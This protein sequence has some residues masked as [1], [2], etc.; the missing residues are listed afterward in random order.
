[1]GN[2]FK[3]SAILFFVAAFA[4]GLLAFYNS[5]TA[6]V[7]KEMNKAKEEKARKYV[8]PDAVEFKAVNY[9]SD[10]ND[11]YYEAHDKDGETIGFVYLSRKN[12]FS[13]MVETMVGTDTDFKIIDIKVVKHSETP[14]LG[15]ESQKIKYGEEKPFFEKW[16]IG[17]NAL[18]VVVEKDDNKSAD[19]VQSI[20]GS[21]ITTRAV[22]RGIN[23][24]S[25]MVKETIEKNKG[26]N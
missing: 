6:P 3:L 15:A 26:G 1:M 13:G 7:I 22:C 21:T 17:K 20:T 18:K 16:F 8:M 10:E 23:I 2:I 11:K 24:Y 9:A 19:K 25:E 14:G 12:G 4:A 5:L